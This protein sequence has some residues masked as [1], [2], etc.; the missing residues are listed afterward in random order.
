MNRFIISLTL[1]IVLLVNTH[2]TNA[3]NIYDQYIEV[4]SDYDQI[5]VRVEN[6]KKLKL[7]EYT[8]IVYIAKDK[9]KLLTYPDGYAELTLKNVNKKYSIFTL[10]RELFLNKSAATLVEYLPT[11]G[12]YYYQIYLNYDLFNEDDSISED[13]YLN[14]LV[15]E[16]TME[17]TH[18][19]DTLKYLQ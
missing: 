13:D 8:Y 9:E 11:K 2:Y 10:K 1:S 18:D 16:G 15:K 17:T 4:T 12:T 19:F 14:H 6:N 5:M 3:S 7:S